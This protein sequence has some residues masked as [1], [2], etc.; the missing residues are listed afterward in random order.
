[1]SAATP[2]DR[3]LVCARC[4][5]TYASE[6]AAQP[7]AGSEPAT[8]EVSVLLDFGDGSR[9]ELQV[10]ATDPDEALAEARDYVLDNAYLVVEDADT[11]ATLAEGMLR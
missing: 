11:G 2:E 3:P 8:A 4:G 10:T 9:H 5:L 6:L 7:C 1:V